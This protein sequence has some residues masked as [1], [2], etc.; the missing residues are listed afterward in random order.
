MIISAQVFL[1]GL[2]G[3]LALIKFGYLFWFSMF[4]WTVLSNDVRKKH[5]RTFWLLF[6]GTD[7]MCDDW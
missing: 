3:P 7:V 4:D 6:V 2:T 1:A 5:V